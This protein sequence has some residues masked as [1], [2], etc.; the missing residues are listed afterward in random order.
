LHIDDGAKAFLAA[1]PDG[2]EGITLTLAIMARIVRAYRKHPGIIALATELTSHLP[3]KAFAQEAE[4]LHEFVRDQVRYIRDVRDVE[5]VRTP[6]QVLLMGAGDCDDK[7]TLFCALAESIG[8]HCRF[9]AAGFAGGP[10]EH[11]WPEVRLGDSWVAAEV[12]EPVLLGQ[13]PPRITDFR[14]VT[15]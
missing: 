12:T 11:V 14:I 1:I 6:D 5:T 10:L 8:F 15:V 7:A 9:Y 2:P 4:A 13:R 3:D